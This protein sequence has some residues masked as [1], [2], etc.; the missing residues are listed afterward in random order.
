MS[1]ESKTIYVYANWSDLETT[2]IMGYLNAQSIR[3]KEIFSFEF[4]P[5]WL[6]LRS[7]RMLDPD[8]Q[9]YSGRQY[10]DSGKSNFG[11]F[12]DSSPDRWGR[13][14]MRRREAIRARREDRQVRQLLESDYLLEVND[15]TRMGAL[16][17]KLDES[18]DFINHDSEL[19]APP[20][21]SLREL[22]EACRHYEEENPSDEHKK[23]LAMLL[24]PGSSLGGAR[25][26]A[27]VMDNDGNLWIAKFPSRS[28]LVNTGAWEMV[29]HELASQAGLKMPDCRIE[30]FS[31]HGS[32]FLTKRFDREADKRIHFASAMTLLGRTDGDNYAMGCSYLDLAQ[33]IIQYG[34]M[35]NEDLEELWKRIVFSIA[36]SNTDDHL[37]NHGF[38]LTRQGWI[39]SPAYD[40]NPTPHGSGLSLNI[41]ADDN[42]LD[43]ELALSVAQQFR[44]KMPK[45]Q[46][47]ITGIKKVVSH[48]HEIVLKL[49]IPRTEIESMTPA[50][51]D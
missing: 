22:E 36:I 14:L 7:A 43:F 26:K 35:P 42:S 15:T 1:N 39:L 41:T 9:F 3:G 37:R 31:R 23:W 11:I 28:D 48:W 25:P 33:F 5:D 19:P 4:A 2:V 10:A 24:A 21:T 20:W 16:R 51:H 18:G 46:E 45:A 40:I 44:V 13:Q 17:F 8:L 32:T 29:A 12:L 27:N 34:A 50:F 30:Q 38:L 6:N 47:I 49:K